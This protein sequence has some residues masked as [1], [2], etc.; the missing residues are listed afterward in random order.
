MVGTT[1][2]EI[3]NV[4]PAVGTRL[5]AIGTAVSVGKTIAVSRAEVFAENDGVFTLVCVAT[6]TGRP[7][8]IKK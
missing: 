8:Q 4:A 3:H 5:I 2:F 1:S 6:T 7:L